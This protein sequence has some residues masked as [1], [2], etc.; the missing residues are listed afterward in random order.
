MFPPS[1]AAL[2]VHLAPCIASLFP[3]HKLKWHPSHT[4]RAAC[5]LILATKQVYQINPA[6]KKEEENDMQVAPHIP[7][8]PKDFSSTSDD[9][10]WSAHRLIYSGGG[11]K[12]PLREYIYTFCLSRGIFFGKGQKRRTTPGV[13]WWHLDVLWGI[14]RCGLLVCTVGK[15]ETHVTPCWFRNPK[16]GVR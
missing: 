4:I 13:L 7:T 2:C 1:M 6:W 10:L 14:S 3:R 5:S 16:G 15:R 11:K 9:K 12:L 8:S